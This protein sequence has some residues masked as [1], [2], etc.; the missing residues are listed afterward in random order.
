MEIWVAILNFELED[1]GTVFAIQ[2]NVSAS[3]SPKEFATVTWICRCK[4]G[5]RR[6]SGPN[7]NPANLRKTI[8]LADWMALRIGK[9]PIRHYGNLANPVNIGGLPSYTQIRL[10]RL[11]PIKTYSRLPPMRSPQTHARVEPDTDVFRGDEADGNR[12]LLRLK[13]RL[14]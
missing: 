9:F 3:K 12:V 2:V 7:I 14:C 5:S 4:L 10:R 8:D 13:G 6:Q 11:S 1:L